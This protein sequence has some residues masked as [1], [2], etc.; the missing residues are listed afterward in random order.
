MISTRLMI[1]LMAIYSVIVVGAVFEGNQN[2][3][4]YFFGALLISFAVIRMK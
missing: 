2:R 3:A 4:L 1:F